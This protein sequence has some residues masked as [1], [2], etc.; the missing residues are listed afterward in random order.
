LKFGSWYLKSK[1]ARLLAAPIFY[2]RKFALIRGQMFGGGWA[3]SHVDIGSRCTN[4]DGENLL[5][6]TICR[7]IRPV[8]GRQR[9]AL[10]VRMITSPIFGL[11][12][13]WARG[14]NNHTMAIIARLAGEG[15][16]P[17][18]SFDFDFSDADGNPHPGPHIFAG[19]NGSGKST[20][21]RTLAWMFERPGAA[22]GFPWQEWQHLIAGHSLTR[23]MVVVNLPGVEPFAWAQ[24]LDTS[25]G[26]NERLRSWMNR[27]LFDSKEISCRSE[28]PVAFQEVW[29]NINP[30]EAAST[31]QAD[32]VSRQPTG[33][34]R[35][36]GPNKL[37]WRQRVLAAAYGP[38]RLLRHLAWV[39]LAVQL[40]NSKENALSFE[41][42]VRNEVVQSWLVSLLSRQALAKQ[43]GQSEEKYRVALGR[44]QMALQH[45]CQQPIEFN[46]EIEPSIHP[47]LWMYKRWL[48]FSQLPDGV[49]STVG[50]LGDFMMRMDIH[51]RPS[52]TENDT[53]ASVLLLDE[54]DAHL[55]PKWQ[56]SILPSIKKALP[57]VQVFATSHS[58]FVIASCPGARIHVLELDD[59]GHAH[60]R[61]AEDAPIGESILATMKDIFGVDSRFD[62]DTEKL[63][64]E[65]NQL[66]RSQVAGK[67]SANDKERITKLSQELGSRSEELRQIVSP[68]IHLSDS[69]LASLQ[70]QSEPAGRRPAKTRARK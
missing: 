13:H 50:W 28:Q 51:D 25:E 9:I 3:E 47:K 70:P 11:H 48:D 35:I 60:N 49:R 23:A 65:W 68:V 27:L 43:R 66:R 59:D 7:A 61:P 38:S 64:E 24:T 32:L 30:I 33:Y 62:V 69:L 45:I 18:K 40:K 5:S 19:I 56:R 12:Y 14:Y 26:W 57:E 58:P 34:M 54:V 21:L 6:I 63:L 42:T 36:G 22:D 52:H 8:P 41:S 67:L 1:W 2:S 44:F 53:T 20:I 46:V 37:G 39:D 16:G 17:F 10:D 55:H 4:S 29:P 31:R 15:I